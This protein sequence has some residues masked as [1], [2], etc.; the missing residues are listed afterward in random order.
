MDE[1]HWW[2]ASKLQETFHFGGYDNPT[3][4]EDFLSQPDVVDLINRFLG[5]GEPNKL[6]FY[7]DE[8]PAGGA[9][10]PSTSRQLCVVSQLGKDIIYLGKV[11]LYMLR[12]NTG[13]EVDLTQMEK[14]IFCGEL[15]HSVLSS[16]AALLTE[17]YGPLLHSQKDWGDCPHETVTNFLQNV[18][19]FSASVMDLATFSQIH[20]SPLQRPSA[21]LRNEIIQSQSKG[22]LSGDADLLTSCESLVNDWIGTI[23]SLLMD[24]TDERLC[25]T[26]VKGFVLLLHSTKGE[27]EKRDWKD[28]VGWGREGTPPNRI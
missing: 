2:F 14:E 16:F 10:A 6:F 8:L 17:A 23:E 19:K 20:Q 3:L 24:T 11:C 1:R 7:C 21:A 18:S 15:K 26:L 28:R 12:I 27:G 22:L 4:L 13:G 25:H 5:P 9:R